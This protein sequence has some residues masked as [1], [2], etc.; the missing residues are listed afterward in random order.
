MRLSVAS[1]QIVEHKNLW[2]LCDGKPDAE[3]KQLTFGRILKNWRTNAIVMLFVLS[4]EHRSVLVVLTRK[5]S[6]L[7]VIVIE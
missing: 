6:E 4:L 3:M 7:C 5:T 2:Y 1:S